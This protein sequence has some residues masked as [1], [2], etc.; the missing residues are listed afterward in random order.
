[1]CCIWA[2]NFFVLNLFDYDDF[3]CENIIVKDFGVS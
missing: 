1:M 2:T 3:N